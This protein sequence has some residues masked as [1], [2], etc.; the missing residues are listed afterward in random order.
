VLVN[1]LLGQNGFLTAGLMG[2]ALAFMERRPLLS[3]IFLGFLTYKPH[4]G[5]L[6]PFAPWRRVIG[7]PSAARW[8]Q[9]WCW[10]W[11]W[12]SFFVPKDG[13]L[14]YT[15]CSAATRASARSRGSKYAPSVSFALLHWLGPTL[16]VSLIVHLAGAA[17]VA[18]A[19][20]VVWAKQIPHSLKAALL[21]IGSVTVTPYVLAYDLC[22][23]SVA[24]AFLV[25]DGLARGFLSG[26]R[27]VMLFCCAGLFL[28]LTPIPPIGPIICAVLIM[29]VVRR[30]AAYQKGVLPSAIRSPEHE[31]PSLAGTALPQRG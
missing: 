21:C 11:Q 25:S 14:S 13:P 26:E 7:G 29:L 17:V 23:L 28:L 18:I 16:S 2:L 4:F 15:R 5:L 6:F 9:A 31:R 19:V 12:R 30:I 27:T 20:C 1:V 22:I 3:G 8:Q 10:F 24:V